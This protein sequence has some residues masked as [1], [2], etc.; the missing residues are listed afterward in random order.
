MNGMCDVYE[1]N[2]SWLMSNEPFTHVQVVMAMAI[3]GL[4]TQ[5]GLAALACNKGKS[6]LEE[7]GS[8]L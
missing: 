8:L 7:G 4:S 1:R 5:F 3:S 2:V 6:V